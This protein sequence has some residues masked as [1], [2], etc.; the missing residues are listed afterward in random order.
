ME[1]C[2]L[3]VIE[4]NLFAKNPNLEWVSLHSNNIKQ[5]A[6]DI[7]QSLK[8]SIHIDLKDNICINRASDGGTLYNELNS[9]VRIGCVESH[10]TCQDADIC[11]RIAVLE[12]ALVSLRNGD[13]KKCEQW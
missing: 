2:S 6:A 3:E 8:P 7:I 11:S 10:G 4:S 9:F 5:V 12:I 13:G 1:K